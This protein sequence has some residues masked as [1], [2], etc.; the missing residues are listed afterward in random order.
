MDYYRN[1]AGFTLIELLVVFAIIGILAA[2]AIAHYADSQGRALDVAA[3]SDLRNFYSVIS[4][5]AASDTNG[6]YVPDGGFICSDT[7]ECRAEYPQLVASHDNRLCLQI[8]AHEITR[9]CVCHNGGT[10]AGYCLENGR[11]NAKNICGC[12]N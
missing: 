10:V 12:G 2:I 1:S 6:Y 5:R 7:A 9:I 4:N 8:T 11:Q 3:R